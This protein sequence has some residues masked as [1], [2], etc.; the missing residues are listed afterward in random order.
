MTPT[1][2]R[3]CRSDH[4]KLK[5]PL[6]LPA[7]FSGT[8]ALMA[9]KQLLKVIGALLGVGGIGAV[10]I[11]V[12]DHV[13]DKKMINVSTCTP[14]ETQLCGCGQ[15]IR[16]CAE[17]GRRWSRCKCDPVEVTSRT[18]TNEFCLI[19]STPP[20]GVLGCFDTT[21]RCEAQKW[22]LSAMVDEDGQQ[23]YPAMDC[24]VNPAVFACITWYDEKGAP[25]LW[26]YASTEDCAS[27]GLGNCSLVRRR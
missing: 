3:R 8:I 6:V 24:V 19:A 15:D 7:E 5:L 2:K 13:H 18:S 14:N 17:D 11:N 1:W 20:R 10:A 26:C 16:T 9:T 12:M 23:Y 25:Q 22:T 27:Q 21:A 4:R